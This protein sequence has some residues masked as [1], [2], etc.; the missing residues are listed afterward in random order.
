MIKEFTLK[1]C[2][3]T[4]D[5]PDNPEILDNMKTMLD[6]INPDVSDWEL[7]YMVVDYIINILKNEVIILTA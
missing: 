3:D 2:I 1:L 5:Y 4:D 7:N 6:L